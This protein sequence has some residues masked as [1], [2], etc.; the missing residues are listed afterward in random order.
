MKKSL[1]LVYRST[2]GSPGR[3]QACM[4]WLVSSHHEHIRPPWLSWSSVHFYLFSIIIFRYDYNLCMYSYWSDAINLIFWQEITFLT[5][6]SIYSLHQKPNIEH[7]IMYQFDG[8]FSACAV[9]VFLVIRVFFFDRRRHPNSIYLW[10]FRSISIS[11]L[12][13]NLGIFLSPFVI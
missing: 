3:L 12:S 4:R 8:I 2:A 11:C 9:Y 10:L 1:R 5:Q 7:V 13:S 6:I